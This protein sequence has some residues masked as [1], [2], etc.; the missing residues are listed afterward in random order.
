MK[1]QVIASATIAVALAVVSSA[2]LAQFGQGYGRSRYPAKLRPA[3]QR[4]DG[5]SFCRLMYASA[6]RGRGMGRWSTDY[7]FAD[8][9]FMIR[10][11]EMSTTDVH[12]DADDEP[13]HWVVPVTDD[14]LFSCP[15]IIA[16]AVGSM[17]LAPTEAENLRNYLLKG[18]FLWVDDFW[19]SWEWDQWLSLIHIS[20]HT[21]LGMIS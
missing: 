19:G 9:N 12:F 4:D 13:I 20:E 1:R 11:S 18:G 6:Y 3:D 15:F 8:I 7:P 2:T 10:L 21:R 17:G 14:T 16:S 5:F